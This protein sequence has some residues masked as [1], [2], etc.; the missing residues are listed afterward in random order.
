MITSQQT[1]EATNQKK[2][3]LKPPINSTNQTNMESLLNFNWE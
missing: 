1:G 3:K 2:K